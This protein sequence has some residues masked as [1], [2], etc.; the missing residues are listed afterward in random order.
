MASVLRAGLALLLCVP[1]L[2]ATISPAQAARSRVVISQQVA[3]PGE[4]VRFTGN[5]RGRVRR[6]VQLQMLVRGTWKVKRRASTTRSGTFAFRLPAPSTSRRVRVVAPRKRI[7]RTWRSRVVLRTTLRVQ[8]QTQTSAQ[9]AGVVIEGAP[10]LIQARFSPARPGRLVDLQRLSGTRWVTLRTLRADARGAVRASLATTAPG[11]YRHRLVARPYAGA[12]AQ[13][14]SAWRLD[15]LAR[16][17]EGVRFAGLVAG[18]TMT[19]RQPIDLTVPA[20]V[21]PDRVGL[22]AGGKPAGVASLQLSGV[23][24]VEL[25]TTELDNGH[26]DLTALVTAGDRRG[27][28]ESVPVV[29]RNDQ[30]ERAEVAAGFRIETV[31]D[32]LEL[33]TAF[34]FAGDQRILVAEKSGRVRLIEDGVLQ[35]GSV[36]DLSSQVATDTDLGLVGMVTDPDFTVNG[37]V[38]LAMILRRNA[39][40]EAAYPGSLRYPQQVVRYTMV[41]DRI[42]AASAHVVLGGNRGPA[43]LADPTVADCMQID[44]AS[45]TVDDLE[46]DA[47]GNLLVA[48]GDGRPGIFFGDDIMRDVLYRVQNEHTLNGKLLRVDPVTGRGVPAN[49]MYDA[50]HP[51]ANRGRVL[52]T[53]LRNPFRMTVDE[54]RVIIGDVGELAAEEVNVLAAG[55]TANFGWP[56]FEATGKSFAAAEPGC[57]DLVEPSG[58][59]SDGPGGGAGHTQPI[60]YYNHENWAGALTGGVVYRGENYPKEYLGRYFA[61]DYVFQRIFAIDLADPPAGGP[62]FPAFAA[63]SGTGGPVQFALGPDGNVWYV[64]VTT[65]LLNRI[66]Y[67]ADGAE[68]GDEEYVATYYDN[69]RF[70]GTPQRIRCEPAGP[71]QPGWELPPELVGG[72]Y[73][74]SWTGNPSMTAGSYRVEKSSTGNLTL[75]VAG[76]SIESRFRVD[77]SQTATRDPRPAV[78]IGLS[79][80]GP[81]PA[82]SLSWARIG[83]APAVRI[84][85]PRQGERLP[86]GA[87]LSWSVSALDD[88]DGVLDPAGIGTQV[89]VLHYGTQDVHSHPTIVRGERHSM[90]VDDSHAP[91]QIALRITAMATDS[92]GSIGRSAPVYVCLEGGEVGPCA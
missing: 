86:V 64:S 43:C 42:D 78:R 31:A 9:S 46:F 11:S 1:L 18:Q 3:M 54:G 85:G 77:A 82:L 6:P 72:D 92:D 76:R 61:G 26:T 5:V 59:S 19:G 55:Q 50:E 40:E 15:V 91:G 25:D 7:H 29:I 58:G 39:E 17:F 80:S 48:V 8:R 21:R 37:F 67:D 38:Y 16:H 35:P 74:V 71:G 27:V 28:S 62:A 36:L 70:E 89:E 22:L 45:H 69:D 30:S 47:D 2:A 73:S 87:T 56:C 57:A 65:G 13:P 68:C 84:H 33:P 41:G 10:A 34:A 66:V 79:G 81:D 20:G 24:R 52:A 53:G 63:G 49:P 23:W 51:D 14:T 44:G 60:A 83:S 75:D 4:L 32:G 88:E 12:A 90:R